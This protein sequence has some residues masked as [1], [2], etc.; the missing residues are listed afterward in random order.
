MSFGAFILTNTGPSGSFTY[1]GAEHANAITE[2][3][4]E[5]HLDK[6]TTF[7][8]RFQEDFENQ[9]EVEAAQ[10]LF[11]KSLGIAIC[12]SDGT[13]PSV[14]GLIPPTL[15]CLV[16]GQVE[17]VEFNVT[18]GGSGSWF[19][20]RGQDIRTEV[21][22]NVDII[23]EEGSTKDI[24]S[25]LVG[26]FADEYT[27]GDEI[28]NYIDN[29]Y[30]FRGSALEAVYDLARKSNYSFWMKYELEAMGADGFVVKSHAHVEPSPPRKEQEEPPTQFDGLELVAP[31]KAPQL[32]ILGTEEDCET[33]VNFSSRV[34]NEAYRLAKSTAQNLD[35][36]EAQD[37]DEATTEDKEL[38]PGGENSS[39]VGATD[40]EEPPALESPSPVPG[41]KSVLVGPEPEHELSPWQAYA[42]ATEASW[43]VQGEALTTVHML[44]SVV[45]PHDIVQVIGGGCGVAGL[46]QVTDVTHVINAAEHWME[47][48]LRSNSRSLK[49]HPNL[50]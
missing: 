17:N 10:A 20:I 40:Q 7:A 6:Q 18:V 35:N 36:G 33:V 11:S 25:A 43:Y 3:R 31:E 48:K 38:N 39:S 50:P 1:L 21:N 34:D 30:V 27:V 37:T 15:V 16:K 5:Q 19:E 12:T 26:L 23:V 49:A 13:P 29:S 45:Q 22:R 14:G 2:I 9:E 32:R 46:Y 41:F 24:I 28:K 44:Q 4:I 8:V 47:L 42:A